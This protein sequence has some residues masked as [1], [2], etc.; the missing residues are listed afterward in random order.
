MFGDGF[1]IFTEVGKPRVVYVGKTHFSHLTT[2]TMT[3]T[4]K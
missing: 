1:R 3:M 2:M 4:M